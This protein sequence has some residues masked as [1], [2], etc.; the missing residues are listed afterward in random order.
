[1]CFAGL[2][3]AD[4]EQQNRKWKLHNMDFK[5][6]IFDREVHWIMLPSSPE[7]PESP[8]FCHSGSIARLT[9]DGG[10]GG[11]ARS[12]NEVSV[13]SPSLSESLYIL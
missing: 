6:F 2:Y 11:E 5:A 3:V 4:L 7:S 13:V 1:M 12:R 8:N 9:E 10:N